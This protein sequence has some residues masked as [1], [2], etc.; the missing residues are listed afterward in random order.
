MRLRT[1][2]SSRPPALPMLHDAIRTIASTWSAT[3]PTPRT[4]P[5][6]SMAVVPAC[7]TVSP[8]RTAREK[9]L[10]CSSCR[11][12]AT[13][14]RRDVAMM[15]SDVGRALL[16]ELQVLVRR[17]V[18]MIRDE[19]ET[20]LFHAR[21]N[22]V[23]EAELPERREH[24]ALVG[25][26]LDLVE[27]RLAT[28]GIEFPRLLHEEIFHV[29]V[30]TPGVEAFL[31]VVVLDTC[32]GV[33]HAAG[34]GLEEPGDLLVLPLRQESGTLHRTHLGADADRRQVV[35]DGLGHAPVRAVARIVPRVE[36]VRIAGLGQELLRLRHVVRIC[37]DRQRVLVG[38]GNDA[39][40]D[41]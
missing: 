24:D 8:T 22:R 34:A 13:F 15:S 29:R 30:A 9:C 38:R 5:C 11:P 25:Q 1:T 41:A 33:A 27:Q 18:R 31:D 17:G 16:P 12:E 32:R 4:L 14:T 10:S 28:L 26:T 37:R 3:L 40:R 19:P 20:G 6:R 35:R 7:S 2:S 36:S 23:Q 39:A 21:S